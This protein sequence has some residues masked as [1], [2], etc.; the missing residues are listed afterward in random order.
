MSKQDDYYFTFLKYAREKLDV[1]EGTVDYSDVLK[2]VRQIHDEVS[3]PAFKRTFLQAV[4]PVRD[5]GRG[6]VESDIAGGERM[7]L[8]LEAYF[9]LLEHEELQE[10]RRASKK[11]ESH[12]I[13]ALVIAIF[14]GVSSIAFSTLERNTQNVVII[15]PDQVETIQ[16]FIREE[17][18]RLEMK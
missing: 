10:A 8:A 7:V 17:T 5:L 18:N 2:H 9:H 3:E 16:E 4:V 11:A 12:A 14:I 6:P 15:N 1:G 13:W